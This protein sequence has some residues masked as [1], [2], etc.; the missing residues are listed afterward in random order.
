MTKRILGLALGLLFLLSQ[1]VFAENWI[2]VKRVEKY[3]ERTTFIDK[4]SIQLKEGT[5]EGT[6]LV[7]TMRRINKNSYNE[8]VIITTTTRVYFPT[9]SRNYYCQSSED[10]LKIGNN[11]AFLDT[12]TPLRR[13]PRIAEVTDLEEKEYLRSYW[14]DISDALRLYR[15]I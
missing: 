5:P 7:F 15:N 14:L 1:G 9:P 8:D 6:L 12:S 4:D 2:E 11:Q 10:Y 13:L 3:A